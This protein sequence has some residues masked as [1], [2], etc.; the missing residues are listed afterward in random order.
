MSDFTPRD[1]DWHRRVEEDF[2]SQGF[3]HHI[4]AELVALTPGRCEI[5]LPYR[6][7]LS[8]HHSFFHGGVIGTIADN[9]GGFAGGSLLEAGQE[10]LTVEYKLNIVAPGR[11]DC[12]V[13]IGSVVKAGRTLLVTRADVFAETAGRRKLCAI[14]QQTL[15]CVAAEVTR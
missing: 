13:A 6:P 12:L 5:R 4:G 10:V 14:A 3:M 7:E 15:M 9:A 8:Q 1:P 11:G 2:A